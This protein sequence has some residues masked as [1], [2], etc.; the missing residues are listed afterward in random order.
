MKK[1][2]LLLTAFVILSIAAGQKYELAQ[3]TKRWQLIVDPYEFEKI[4][5]LYQEGL[6]QI[7]TITI[8]PQE[9]YELK[10]LTMDSLEQ[11]PPDILALMGCNDVDEL[12]AKMKESLYEIKQKEDSVLRNMVVVYDFEKTGVIRRFIP[13]RADLT[14]TSVS[15]HYDKSKNRVVFFANPKDYNH[16]KKDSG[17]CEILYLDDDSLSLK[18]DTKR[19]IGVISELKTMNFIRFKEEE[20][21]R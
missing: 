5:S 19:T 18:I 7:D 3:L 2:A 9:I 8:F 16:T 13:N 12:K 6:Q 1:S 10:S 17:F 20:V 11:Y 4:D 15:F 14:D 21:M